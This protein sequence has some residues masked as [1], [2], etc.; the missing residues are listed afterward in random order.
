MTIPLCGPLGFTYPVYTALFNLSKTWQHLYQER[1]KDESKYM[2]RIVHDDMAYDNG[3]GVEGATLEIVAM[4]V[5][6]FK[7]SSFHFCTV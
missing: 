2:H 3:N 4:V 1:C 5:V 7:A 6:P